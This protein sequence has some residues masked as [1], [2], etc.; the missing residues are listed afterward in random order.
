MG[1]LLAFLLLVSALGACSAKEDP[2]KPSGPTR[3]VTHAMGTTQVPDKPQR[4]VVLDTPELDAAITLGVKPVGTVSFGTG[5]S[6]RDLVLSDDAKTLF[7]LTVPTSG[8]AKSQ[9]VPIDTSTRKAGKP[10]DLPDPAWRM[11]ASAGT[12]DSNARRPRRVRA[13]AYSSRPSLME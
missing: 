3:S 13:T 2:S 10:L 1:P 4:V 6:V 5:R 11:V 7:A 9:I 8:K 12:R